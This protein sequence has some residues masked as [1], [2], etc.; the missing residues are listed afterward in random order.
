MIPPINFSV[1]EMRYLRAK[2]KIDYAAIKKQQEVN[3]KESST[4]WRAFDRPRAIK[5]F[6]DFTRISQNY[7]FIFLNI[8]TEL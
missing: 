4:S 2:Q 5:N 1:L 8:F 3:E 6:G 7:P